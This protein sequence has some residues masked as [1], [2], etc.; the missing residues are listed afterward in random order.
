MANQSQKINNELTLRPYRNGVALA[1]PNDL[2]ERP[3]LKDIFDL[4]LQCYFYNLNNCFIQINQTTAEINGFNS[5]N[6]AAGKT[7]RDIAK[8]QTSTQILSHNESIL[9]NRTMLIVDESIL[10]KDDIFFTGISIKFPWYDRNKLIG[11]FGCSFVIDSVKSYVDGLTLIAKTGLLNLPSTGIK[12][13]I[14]EYYFS[15]REKEIISHLIRGKTAR[16]IA[17]HTNLSKRTVEHYLENIKAK[18]QS[19]SKSELIDK[20]VEFFQ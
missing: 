19:D 7:I 8:G 12:K 1:C 13:R 16:E 6:D 4:P 3:V 17:E 18:T 15:I 2:I 20:L 10:R 11:I 9:R 14:S 5:E